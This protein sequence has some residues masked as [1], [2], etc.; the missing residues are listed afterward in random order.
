MSD[1]VT[2]IRMRISQVASLLQLSEEASELAQAACKMARII[3]GTNPTPVTMEEASNA[4]HEE[5]ND[6]INAAKV[7]GLTD[8]RIQQFDKLSRWAARLDEKEHGT[9]EHHDER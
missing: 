8:S 7:A 3:D 1:I 9:N 6:V 4:L 5:Y 2:N